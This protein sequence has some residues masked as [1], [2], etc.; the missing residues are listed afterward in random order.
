MRCVATSA[1]TEALA[2][3][4]GLDVRAPDEVGRLD[5]AIDGADEVDPAGNLIKGGGGAHTREKVVAEMADRF[6]VV[7]D[8]TKLVP[9]LG[10]FGV[11]VEVLDFAPGVVADRLASAGGV[12]G[13]G[14]RRP[15]GQRQPALPGPFRPHRRPRRP[16]RCAG[17][18]SRRWS[19]TA[20]SWPDIGRPVLVA[21]EDGPVEEAAVDGYPRPRSAGAA[22]GGC[23][24]DRVRGG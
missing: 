1:R 4:V 3:S 6:V 22:G 7:V 12:G 23:A 2:R 11:P 8:R 14:D 24:V 21:G 9:V 5:L 13:R 10:D 16:G 15:F 19:S 18:R 17:R 20:C